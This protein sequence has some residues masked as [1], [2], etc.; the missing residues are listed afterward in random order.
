[1]VIVITDPTDSELR[2]VIIDIITG[3]EF[4]KW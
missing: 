3:S 2:T 1:M 4:K